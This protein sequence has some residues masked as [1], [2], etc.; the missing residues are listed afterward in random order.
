[1]ATPIAEQDSSLAKALARA[2]AL[3]VREPGAPSAAA[4]APCRILRFARLGA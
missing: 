3:L 1:V 2:D 4:G